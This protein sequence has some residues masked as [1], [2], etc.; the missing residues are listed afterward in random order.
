MSQMYATSLVPQTS[1]TLGQTVYGTPISGYTHYGYGG[2]DVGWGD[3]YHEIKTAIKTLASACMHLLDQSIMNE[4]EAVSVLVKLHKELSE[5]LTIQQVADTIDNAPKI[6]MNS[7]VSAAFTYN[8]GSVPYT[9]NVTFTNTGTFPG[10]TV[11]LGTVSSTTKR[12][13]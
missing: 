1:V 2:V 8:A 3:P 5:D 4:Q 6:N 9:G 10:Q 13:P 11:T 7:N 12:L